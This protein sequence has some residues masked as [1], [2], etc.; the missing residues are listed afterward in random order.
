MTPTTW[1]PRGRGRQ[2][3][4]LSC[5]ALRFEVRRNFS[6]RMMHACVTL[7]RFDVGI[8]S[9]QRELDW[10]LPVSVSARSVASCQRH[11]SDW[12]TAGATN[13]LNLFYFAALPAVTAPNNLTALQHLFNKSKWGKCIKTLELSLHTCQGF[14]MTIGVTK[15]R[16]CFYPWAVSH[17]SISFVC[18]EG[19][20]NKKNSIGLNKN[21]D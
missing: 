4:S 13:Q 1:T 15:G 10:L 11:K 7:W 21:V 9:K 19:K 3:S 14:A 18:L 16:H 8:S 17:N 5:A 2:G 20:E 12:R 6:F